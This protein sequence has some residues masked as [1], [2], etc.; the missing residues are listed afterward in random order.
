MSFLLALTG[1]IGMGKSTAARL[2]AENGAEVWDAD[3]AVHELYSPGNAGAE[4]LRDIAPEAVEPSGVNREILSK[5]IAADPTLLDKIEEAIHPLVWEHREGFIASKQ[6]ALLVFEI[7][8]LFETG[9]EAK[10]DAVA[11]VTTSAELQ[12]ERALRRDGMTNDKFEMIL[13]KQVP[14]A[15][16]RLKAD[17]LID[18]T[19]LDSARADVDR[20][21]TEIESKQ[22]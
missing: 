12:R 16:K 9:I 11:V 13:A 14:D 21:M 4:A 15:E 5:K 3:S 1:S 18:S 8:L 2:F 17:Y 20:V 6:K 19:T 22:L 7:P 10:F